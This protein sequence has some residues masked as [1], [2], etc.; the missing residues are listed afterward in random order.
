MRLKI[1]IEDS[2]SA[3][4]VVELFFFPSTMFLLQYYQKTI[5][6][7]FRSQSRGPVCTMVAQI[8]AHLSHRQVDAI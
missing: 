2:Y 1:R 8:R 4:L 6:F 7:T 3:G 5:S